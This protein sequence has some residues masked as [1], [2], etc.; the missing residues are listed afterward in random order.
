MSSIP[1]YV[2]AHHHRVRVL[3]CMWDWQSAP[4]AA[5]SLKQQRCLHVQP[6]AVGFLNFSH[7]T[8]SATLVSCLEVTAPL[9]LLSFF[10]FQF[11]QLNTE[12][13]DA[14]TAAFQNAVLFLT[15]YWTLSFWNQISTF[16]SFLC[17]CVLH[18]YLWKYFL[19]P[20]NERG[21]ATGR[22]VRATA[23]PCHSWIT[24]LVNSLP[25]EIFW[26]MHLFCYVHINTV[27]LDP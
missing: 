26:Y 9:K 7:Q 10:F 12:V 6:V 11:P 19:N 1:L 3:Y 16:D 21:E 8:T 2:Q 15:F 13:K 27:F 22:P 17:E 5:H 4:R 18:F 25:Y 14:A 23:T 24:L 20:V